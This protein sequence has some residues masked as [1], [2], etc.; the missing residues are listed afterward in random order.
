MSDLSF[1]QP[2][3][4]NFLVPALVVAVIVAIAFALIYFLLPHRIADLTVTHVAI[5][6]EHTVFATGSKVVGARDEAQDDLYV[7]ASVRIDDRL[8]I[9]LFINDITGTLTTQDGTDL[10][11]SAV[12]KGDLDAVYMAFPALKPMST[13]AGPP[14][15]R[16]TEIQPGRSAEG[17]V[18]LHYSATEA[19]WKQRKGASVTIDFYHQGPFTVAIPTP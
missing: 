1:S 7:L 17:M 10:T 5:Q 2:E 18:L 3:R 14:L 19:A 16:E 6:P 8:K 12:E 15:L 11:T 13:Q 4:R 9:P